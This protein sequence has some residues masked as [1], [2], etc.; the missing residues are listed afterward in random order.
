M[1]AI[2]T[3]HPLA[4]WD[5]PADFPAGYVAHICN[6]HSTI[7]MAV[8]EPCYT[9]EFCEAC[10]EGCACGCGVETR[11]GRY[12]PGHDARNPEKEVCVYCKFSLAKRALQPVPDVEGWQCKSIRACT[13]RQSSLRHH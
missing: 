7:V 12:L 5:E 10:R 3:R 4:D 1:T 2:A 11:G 9:S 13:R 6:T 8:N